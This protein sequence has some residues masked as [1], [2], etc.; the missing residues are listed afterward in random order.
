MRFAKSACAVL[1][2]L[3]LS[4]SPL[5]AVCNY[6]EPNTSSPTYASTALSRPM[7]ANGR[8][9]G[10]GPGDPVAKTPAG[11]VY[12]GSSS[13]S[14][15]IPVLHLAGRNGLDLDLGKV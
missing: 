2:L 7:Q 9:Y 14:K 8:G 15:A 5:L 4:S 11:V 12:L 10:D 3:V 13:Y 1:A 6:C